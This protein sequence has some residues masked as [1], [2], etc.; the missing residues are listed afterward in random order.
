MT[1]SWI[2]RLVLLGLRV[3]DAVTNRKRSEPEPSAS[4]R[5]IA[6]DVAAAETARQEGKRAKALTDEARRREIA[7]HGR[8]LQRDHL[9][10]TMCNCKCCVGFYEER[11]REIR[12]H[13]RIM[14]P[15]HLP[16]PMCN[17]NCCIGFYNRRKR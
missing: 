9:P 4:Q 3:L 1:L 5:D 15:D 14:E 11:R 2:E 13:G 6:I 12:V 8:I 17:C 16:H 7:A 10:H